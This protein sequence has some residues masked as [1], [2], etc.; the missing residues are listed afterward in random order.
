MPNYVVNNVYLSGDFMSRD[1]LVKLGLGDD[2]LRR[3][4]LTKLIPMPR[5]LEN[6]ATWISDDH[7]PAYWEKS[8]RAFAETGFHDW[9]MWRL[10]HW[11]SKWSEVDFEVVDHDRDGDTH[12]RFLSAWS[13]PLEGY[14]RIS[15]VYSMLYFTL[16]YL[17]P[18]LGFVGV[19][20]FHNG[21][22]IASFD[23]QL[24]GQDVDDPD[25]ACLELL[26]PL[27]DRADAV[28]SLYRQ[29]DPV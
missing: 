26:R 15:A 20:V 29:G 3:G 2:P 14:R 12:L 1:N 28:V 24:D 18:G 16:D 11:G 10:A 9:Y 5:V 8:R 27:C 13:P 19:D 7:D 4:L 6:T 23:D 22:T 21:A 17:E 25:D